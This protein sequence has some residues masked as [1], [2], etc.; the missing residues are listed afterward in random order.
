MANQKSNE[1]VP[2]KTS[3]TLNAGIPVEEDKLTRRYDPVEQMEYLCVR[4]VRARDLPGIPAPTA[5]D[6]YVE[7]KI[8]NY[9]FRKPPFSV[10]NQVFAFEKDKILDLIMEVVVKKQSNSAS[11]IVGQIKIILPVV[12]KRVP[13]EGPLAPAWH[14]LEKNPGHSLQMDI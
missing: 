1:F 9:F 11:F 3:T 5:C 8:G 4:I 6:P 10:W 14:K 12:P 13:P 2:K 7:L